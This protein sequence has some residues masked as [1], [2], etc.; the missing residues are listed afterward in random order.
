MEFR[1]TQYQ[2]A[3]NSALKK[4]SKG[5]P[6]GL[7]V[8]SV[9]NFDSETFSFPPREEPSVLPSVTFIDMARGTIHYSTLQS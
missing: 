9:N 4:A 6:K 5:S 7:V 2:V 8:V 3:D 1:V